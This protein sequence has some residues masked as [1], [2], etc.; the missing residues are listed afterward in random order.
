MAVS[1]APT[2]RV[3][4]RPIDVT[5]ARQILDGRR[6]QDWTDGYPTEG[7]RDIA[8][9]LFERPMRASEEPL[10]RPHQI[11]HAATGLVIG[12]IGCHR[13]P[14]PSGTVEIGYGIAPEWRNQGLTSEA[15]GLLVAAL[16]DAGV[17]TV[18]ARTRTDNVASQAVLRHNAFVQ[19]GAGPDGLLVWR[20]VLRE[21]PPPRRWRRF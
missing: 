5:L 3:E 19:G 18:V 14:D 4:L 9:L 16:A 15:V 7:D 17:R 12:G 10:W 11:V 21:D 13:A 20:L 8:R 1:S 2:R 6:Q